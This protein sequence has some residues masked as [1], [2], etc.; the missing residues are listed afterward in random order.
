MFSL[1]LPIA[2][3]LASAAL[4]APALAEPAL[5]KGK[6]TTLKVT[7]NEVIGKNVNR[8]RLAFPSATG[9]LGMT[10]AGMLMVQGEKRDGSGTVA[11]PYTPT[12]S[13]TTEGYMELVVKDY[14]GVG[15][16]SSH[17]C[18]RGVGDELAVKGCYT[19]IKATANKWKEVGMIAGGSGLT[20][21]LQVVEHLLSL[22]DDRTKMTLIFCNRTEED[23]YLRDYLNGLAAGSGG[24][25]TVHFVVDTATSSDWPASLT[26]YV[27]ADMVSRYLPRP[28]G[29]DNMIMVCGPP[30]MYKAV[31]GPKKFE[32]GKPPK[33]GEVGGVLK[34]LGFTEEGVFKF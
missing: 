25:F 13:E 11:R 2:A 21:M 30:P 14:P 31:C 16:V 12:S 5:D 22:P 34:E 10:T 6:F 4:A 7:S 29:A 1:R 15:N 23:I 27:T 33:Q 19:K 18:S 17:I 20:P 28:D 24:R 32:K 26:G 9:T 8:V 3:A